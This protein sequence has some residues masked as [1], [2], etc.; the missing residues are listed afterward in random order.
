MTTEQ[1]AQ[2]LADYCRKGQ[3]EEAQ[4]ELYADDVVSVE[5]Y[6]TPDFSK[7]EKGLQNIIEKGRRFESMIE[8]MHEMTVKDPIVTGNVIALVMGM[9]LTMKGKGRAKWEELCVYTVKDGK[10]VSEHF[11]M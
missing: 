8:E 11:F 3:F 7:E 10:I 1:I 6:A 4:K 9:D 5:P 2:R